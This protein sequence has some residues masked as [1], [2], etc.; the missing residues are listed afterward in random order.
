MPRNPSL[1]TPAP[2]L[3]AGPF[4]AGPRH[5]SVVWGGSS[6][7]RTAGATRG[8]FQSD[9]GDKGAGTEFMAEK[10]PVFSVGGAW[11]PHWTQTLFLPKNNRKGLTS[12]PDLF[13]LE[14]TP[15]SIQS[16]LLHLHTG[17][18]LTGTWRIIWGARNRTLAHHKQD[19]HPPLH[20]WSGSRSFLKVVA[21]S[22]V[23][24]LAFWGWIL[25]RRVKQDRF[26]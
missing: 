9:A 4:P 11:R 26:C 19:K 13:C 21:E 7:T 14:A 24:V 1:P 12:L 3:S 2:G 18:T 25:I 16:S 23:K 8:P 5:P 15:G 22:V 20:Y 6:C 10:S 17:I